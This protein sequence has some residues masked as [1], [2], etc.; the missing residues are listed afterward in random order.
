M[1]IKERLNKFIKDNS[2]EGKGGLSVMLVMTRYAKEHGLPLDPEA[3]VTKKKG[4][5]IKLS[6]SAVQHILADYG[7]VRVLAKEG[8]R[9]SRGSLGNMQ[10]YVELLNELNRD[11]LAD[12]EVIEKLWIERVKQ[13]FSSKGFTLHYDTAKSLK[14]IVDDI[15]EQ[16]VK[17]QKAGHGTMYVGAVLQHMVAAKLSLV[18]GR[19]IVCRGFSTADASSGE[20]GD[21]EIEDVVIHVT[22]TPGVTLLEKCRQNIDNAKRPM[23]ITP[24]DG[25]AGALSLAKGQ[26]LEQ[27]VDIVEAGQFIAT[28]LYEL[29][30][31]KFTERKITIGKFVDRYNE[32]VSE[33]ETDPGLKIGFGK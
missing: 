31:F 12:M 20:D 10:K 14:F 11:G 4:Q 9:T 16:A 32:I 5:V 21:F 27:R 29:S 23:I 19:K 25:V 17:R 15:L 30:L 22:T 1:K 28:N 13:H 3:L 24:E 2:I 6:K 18:L 8:G 7:I 26:G 33:L